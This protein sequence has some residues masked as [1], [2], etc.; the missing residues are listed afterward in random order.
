MEYLIPIVLVLLI[1]TGFVTYLVLNATKKS[2]P[3]APDES[4]AGDTTEHAGDQSERGHTVDDPE[5]AGEGAG[6]GD[7]DRHRGA[8]HPG[9]GEGSRAVPEPESERLGNRT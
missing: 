4:P 1:V 8:A 5:G 7:A 6:E 2:N 3:A 9:E